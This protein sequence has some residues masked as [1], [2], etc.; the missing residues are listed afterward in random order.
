MV[1]EVTSHHQGNHK[2]H[3]YHVIA[4]TD[5]EWVKVDDI[6]VGLKGRD[7]FKTR[8]FLVDPAVPSSLAVRFVLN[9][10]GRVHDIP[11][12]HVSTYNSFNQVGI[13]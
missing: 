7:F 11:H 12:C 3:D 13:I 2:S 8:D 1:S 4:V 6:Y 9:I 5:G 10:D